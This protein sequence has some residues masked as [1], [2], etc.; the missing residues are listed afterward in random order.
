MKGLQASELIPLGDRKVACS[1]DATKTPGESVSGT[2]SPTA[3]PFS[4]RHPPSQQRWSRLP[5]ESAAF[6]RL[7]EA[8]ARVAEFECPVL[9]TGETGCGK[10]EVARAVHDASPRRDRPFVAVNCGGLVSSL[11][12]SQL[13]GHEKGAFTGAFGPSRGVF[14]AAHGGV[15][16]LDEIGE[17]PLE[18]Q[19][20]LL[21]VLQM[22]EVTPVGSTEA[23]PVDVQ[24]LAATNRD[25]E[26]A[27]EAGDFRED[28]LYRLNTVHLTVPPLRARP[29]DIPRFVAHFSDHFA[30]EYGRPAWQP[31]AETLDRFVQHAWPGNVRQLAQTIQRLYVFGDRIDSV[32]AELFTTAG[33]SPLPTDGG[34][35]ERAAIGGAAKAP[36]AWAPD[37]EPATAGVPTAEPAVPV[38]N[39]DELRR[40]AVRQA[41]VATDGHRGKAAALLGVSLNTMTRLVAES[42][43][44]MTTTRGRRRSVK[45]R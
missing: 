42:C 20:K 15:V 7:E 19:P 30:R 17:L 22:K 24:V 28:L 31:D 9:I 2:A 4:R 16:F 6:R 14:R 10:E 34:P 35:A 3:S 27:V 29:E 8:I 13:F 12:E 5:G 25:L 33:P 41:L 11:A 44:E 1:M 39:L 18:L 43:P 32:L 23:Q 40:L 26:A 45:P 38:F 36:G 37:H 21:R